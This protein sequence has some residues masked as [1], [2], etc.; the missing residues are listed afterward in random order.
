MFFLL[1]LLYF[2]PKTV[3]TP[4]TLP[5]VYLAICFP[6]ASVVEGIFNLPSSIAESAK[7]RFASVDQRLYKILLTL[8]SLEC[9]EEKKRCLSTII[10]SSA[11]TQRNSTH[12]LRLHLHLISSSKC[13]LAAAFTFPCFFEQVM[14]MSSGVFL[15]RIC[16]RKWETRY[17]Y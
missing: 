9:E 15:E 1:L 2:P 11:L 4:A 14:T 16:Q 10:S 8:F 6:G 13:N 5:L 17:N 3:T 12:R 7:W